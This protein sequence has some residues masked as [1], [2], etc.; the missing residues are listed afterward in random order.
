M[1]RSG[2][3]QLSCHVLNS[4]HSEV[5][6][7]CGAEIWQWYQTSM[8]HSN[9]FTLFRVIT[10][11]FTP[12]IFV[13]FRDTSYKLQ[14]ASRYSKTCSANFLDFRRNLRKLIFGIS[15]RLFAQTSTLFWRVEICLECFGNAMKLRKKGLQGCIRSSSILRFGSIGSPSPEGCSFPQPKISDTRNSHGSCERKISCW[16]NRPRGRRAGTVIYDT[17]CGYLTVYSTWFGMIKC[18]RNKKCF[19]QNFVSFSW[20]AS[21]F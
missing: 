14:H 18:D 11:H 10:S 7:H 6:L 5:W 21:C 13:I 16:D 3:N 12:V 1:Y 4:L 2:I 8:K 15:C 9:V 17:A 19:I 20:D